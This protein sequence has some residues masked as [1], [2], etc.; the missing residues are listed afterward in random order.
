MAGDSRELTKALE[1]IL[2]APPL[3]PPER[4]ALHD[5][6]A[7]RDGFEARAAVILATARRLLA[8]DQR[9]PRAYI[10]GHRTEANAPHLTDPAAS[11]P[12]IREAMLGAATE[13]LGIARFLEQPGAAALARTGGGGGRHPSADGRPARPPADCARR[14][15]PGT[16]RPDRRIGGRCAPGGRGLAGTPRDPCAVFLRHRWTGCLSES[17][18]TNRFGRTGRRGS[19]AISARSAWPCN[20]ARSR[21]HRLRALAS[22]CTSTMTTSPR[23]SP[24]GWAMSHPLALRLD[25]QRGQGGAHQAP[26]AHRRHPRAGKPRPRHLAEALRFRRCP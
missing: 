25:R 22:S 14:H 4:L 2:A 3:L 9:A 12:T 18:A 20:R 10:P 13:I 19:S 8:E 23:S 5:R 26:S 7:A 16:G 15:S 17:Y 21:L 6:L 1:E 11:A 24:S